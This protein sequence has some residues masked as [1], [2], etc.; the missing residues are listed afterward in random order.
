MGHPSP[1]SF[2]SRPRSWAH[3]FTTMLGVPVTKSKHDAIVV[4]V[5]RFTKMARFAAT[6]TTVT[7]EETAQLFFE[8]VYRSHGLLEEIDR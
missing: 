2:T 6:T 3:T 1:A 5:D 7:A 4:F 8:N